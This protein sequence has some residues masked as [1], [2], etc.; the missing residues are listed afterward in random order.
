M[1][2]GGTTIGPVDEET[3]NRVREFKQKEGFKSYNE[4]LQSLLEGTDY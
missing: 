2:I 3:R 4:A 1:P